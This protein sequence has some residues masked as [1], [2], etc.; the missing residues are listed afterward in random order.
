MKKALI[1]AIGIAAL[2]GGFAFAQIN[3]QFLKPLEVKANPSAAKVAPT[4]ESLQAE[5][6]KLKQK[7]KT[8]NDEIAALNGRIVNFTSKGGSEVHAYCES[9]FM[10]VNTAGAREDC[11]YSGYVCGEVTGLCKTQ[12]NVTDDCSPGFVCDT[13]VH[14]C[15]RPY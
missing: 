1:I 7:I 13:E 14:V 4:V 3:T 6:A 11:S 8:L 10:S 5:N 2:S 9:Q 12:C 15:V